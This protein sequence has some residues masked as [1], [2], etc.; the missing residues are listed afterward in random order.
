M[1]FTK[2]SFLLI[3]I[4]ISSCSDLR[5]VEDIDFQRGDR[6]YAIP[7]FYSEVSL[8]DVFEGQDNE[9]TD[10]IIH[11]DSTLTLLYSGDVLTQTAGDIFPDIPGGLPIDVTK[12]KDSIPLPFQRLELLEATL[13]GDTLLFAIFSSLEE[14]VAVKITVTSLIDNGAP[15]VIEDTIIYQGEKP[16]IQINKVHMRGLS[17]E[18]YKNSFLVEYEAKDLNGNPVQI[19]KITMIYDE[20]TYSYLEGFFT[21]NEVNIP[22]DEI[23]IEVYDSWINGRLYF[24]EPKVTVLVD[25]SF[26]FPVR[27]DI[28]Y[29]RVIG[30]NG[31]KVDLE[32]PLNDQIDFEYP[33]LN[34]VGQIKSNVIRYDETNSNIEQI[35]NIQP[36][37]LEYDIDAIGNPDQDSTIIGFVTDSSLIRINVTVELPIK[38]WANRFTARD[39]IDFNIDTLDDVK[40][41]EFKMIIDNGMPVTVQTQVYFH[42]EQDQIVDSLFAEKEITIL[43]APIDGSGRAISSTQTIQYETMDRDRLNRLAGATY[44][45]MDVSFLTIDAP[46]QIV[47]IGANDKVS[48]KM[49]AKII[50]E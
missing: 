44:A 16:T 18:L 43:G 48:I 6:E 7:L 9:D 12:N 49:G 46:N 33:R 45:I 13:T 10:L 4:I 32:S 34:E 30:R 29:L 15:L 23:D 36:V 1:N 42:N 22:G 3:L 24:A 17:L 20:M 27:A 25:N 39:T 26:G 41:A 8:V 21:K 11:P 35:L 2:L 40:E 5:D 28:N 37:K 19:D 47:G 31:Q 50:T 38:G 14:D